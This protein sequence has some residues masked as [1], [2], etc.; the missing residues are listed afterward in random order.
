MKSDKKILGYKIAD[1]L[2]Q[3]Y[4]INLLIQKHSMSNDKVIMSVN[5][6]FIEH[7]QDFIDQLNAIFNTYALSVA[8]IN[9]PIVEAKLYKK[10]E[11]EALALSEVHEAEITIK[12]SETKH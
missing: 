10:Y 8:S 4:D 12:K 9:P 1:L 11:V 6:Q 7:R 5:Q 3:V 2:E